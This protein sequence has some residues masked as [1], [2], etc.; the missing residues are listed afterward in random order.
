MAEHDNARVYRRLVDAVSGGDIDVIRRL[1]ERSVA[2][3]VLWHEAGGDAPIR[4]REAV[5]DRLEQ[6]LDSGFE[7]Q[8]E[9]HAVLADDEHV[10][11]L[12]QVHLRAGFD[13]VAYEVAEV[14]HVDEGRIVERWA[15]M[16]AVPE[17]L[18]KFFAQVG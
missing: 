18:Q 11:A 14:L 16:D 6:L 17:R 5:L 4:G 9:A 3:D 2:E 1:A 13:E 12:V 7:T 15:M 8:I 10:V